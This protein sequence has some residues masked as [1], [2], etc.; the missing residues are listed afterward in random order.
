MLPE[1]PICSATILILSWPEM[2][3]SQY[4]GLIRRVHAP[5]L[6][7]DILRR[8]YTPSSS[9]PRDTGWKHRSVAGR[10]QLSR[11]THWRSWIRR[12]LGHALFRLIP[13]RS[14]PRTPGYLTRQ[15]HNSLGTW[16]FRQRH[17]FVHLALFTRQDF[18]NSHN[19]TGR[20]VRL[21]VGG[22]AV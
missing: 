20:V 17:L 5:T 3:T 14:P 8:L 10:G 4:I 18:T 21:E 2:T 19:I 6:L 12:L 11:C 13:P 1:I 22:P 9:E 15:W 16:T 7:F